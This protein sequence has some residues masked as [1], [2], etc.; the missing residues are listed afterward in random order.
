MRKIYTFATFILLI[1]FSDIYPQSVDDI[2]KKFIN[3]LGGTEIINSVKTY[4]LLYKKTLQNQ[5]SFSEQYDTVLLKKPNKSI[6]FGDVLNGYDSE[7]YY[8]TY[9]GDKTVYYNKLPSSSSCY[10]RINFYD[11]SVFFINTYKEGRKIT[12]SGI[13]NSE[14]YSNEA[15][16]LTFKDTCGLFEY[17]FD[18]NNYYLVKVISPLYKESVNYDDYRSVN[19][20]L[21]PYHIRYTNNSWD[22]NKYLTDVSLNSELDDD[23]F[24]LPENS[25]NSDLPFCYRDTIKLSQVT[26]NKYFN[27]L[28]DTGY[29]PASIVFLE[30]YG[31]SLKDKFN[32][33]LREKILSFINEDED[34]GVWELP[35]G[36]NDYSD[37]ESFLQIFVDNYNNLACYDFGLNMS[38]EFLGNDYIAIFLYKDVCY[39][40][41]PYLSQKL[42]FLNESNFDLLLID[43]LFVTGYEKTLQTLMY[44]KFL[45]TEFDHKGINKKILFNYVKNNNNFYFTSRGICF[46]F[47]PGDI[48]Y[49]AAG[50]FDII[51]SYEEMNDILNEKFKSL[52]GIPSRKMTNGANR[53]ITNNHTWIGDGI[54]DDNMSFFNSDKDVSKPPECT[55]LKEV[56]KNIKCKNNYIEFPKKFSLR[57]YIT[58]EGKIDE[59]F[60]VILYGP[61]EF[62]ECIIKPSLKYLKFKPALTDNVPVNCFTVL[63][64]DFS[65]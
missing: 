26:L 62:Y 48:S 54:T 17:Y 45:K 4:K 2:V 3:V 40:N 39:G 50:G 18:K 6:E 9:K 27:N 55:N 23:I 61:D 58:S 28:P 59:T 51:I 57:L 24:K 1:T 65:E 44:K 11:P 46:S 47:A 22:L 49:Y 41:H 56:M 36:Y 37:L 63:N 53:I 12:Y 25:I 32:T 19:G 30:A 10:L 38:L 31:G 21:L 34:M 42:Y 15:Y 64:F 35:G 14:C 52:E 43:D 60:G 7:Y 13:K 16:V 5:E 33:F 8:Y 20:Y 29:A